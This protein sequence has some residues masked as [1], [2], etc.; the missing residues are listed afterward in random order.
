MTFLFIDGALNKGLSPD[1]DS[2]FMKVFCGQFGYIWGPEGHLEL[3][4]LDDYLPVGYLRDLPRLYVVLENSLGYF[5]GYPE[6]RTQQ[7]LVK[8]DGSCNLIRGGTPQGPDRCSRPS[9]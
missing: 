2:L 4:Y 5:L 8:P 6:L 9:L 7:I 1:F 3:P